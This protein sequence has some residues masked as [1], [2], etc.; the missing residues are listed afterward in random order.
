MQ[1]KLCRAKTVMFAE[2]AVFGS[3]DEIEGSSTSVQP[4]PVPKRTPIEN[5]VE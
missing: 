1:E 2:E 3:F 5:D 4:P